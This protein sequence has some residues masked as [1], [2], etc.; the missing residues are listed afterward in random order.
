MERLKAENARLTA[1][2]AVRT[3]ERDHYAAAASRLDAALAETAAQLTDAV[4]RVEEAESEATRER[5]TAVGLFDVIAEI[6]G[7][8]G[9]E[10]GEPEICRKVV[11]AVKKL[12][13]RETAVSSGS[14]AAPGSTRSSQ[15]DFW[16]QM[17]DSHRA[18]V[19][20]EVKS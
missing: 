15:E 17:K 11:T 8:V 2:L 5:Q 20:D 4:K 10:R 16:Q 6:A 13:S 14:V 12:Q 1:E 18:P 7:L 3:D 19:A 9:I